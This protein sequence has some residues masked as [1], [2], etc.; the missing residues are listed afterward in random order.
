MNP[1]VG[2]LFGGGHHQL[3]EPPARNRI[4]LLIRSPTVGLK[5]H[6]AIELMQHPTSHRHQLRLNQG[7]YAR[8]FE[9]RNST[10]RKHQVDRFSR[11]NIG[12]THVRSLV[13]QV[14]R[15]APLRRHLMANNEPTSPAPT[16]VTSGVLFTIIGSPSMFIVPTNDDV[17]LR[18]DDGS[19]DCAS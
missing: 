6:W 14:D 10:F 5:F 19:C 11:G 8:R 2:T 7:K 15:Q 16:M 18:R 4:D 13:I 12:T 3:V 17:L 9:C 1:D